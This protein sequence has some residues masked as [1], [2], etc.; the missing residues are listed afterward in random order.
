MMDLGVLKEYECHFETN[1]VSVENGVSYE[2]SYPTHL[3]F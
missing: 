1:L 3:V 2:E